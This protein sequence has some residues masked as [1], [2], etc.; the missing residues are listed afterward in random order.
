MN[1]LITGGTGLLGKAIINTMRP[2]INIASTFD[3]AY[4]VDNTDIVKHLKV[5][6]LD[7]KSYIDL[8]LSF[9]PEYIIHCAS[10]G[11]PDFAELN[12]DLTWNVNVAGTSNIVDV[13]NS[14]G[15][16]L[17][18]ISSNG[19]YSGDSPPYSEDSPANPINFYGMTKLEGEKISKTA[20]NGC[21]IVRPILM[22]G[23]NNSFERK[24]IVTSSL[25]K[26]RRNEIVYA[27]NDVFVSP[28]Y[29][30]QCASAI[31]NIITN[32]IAGDFNIG[33]AERA[34][35]YDLLLKTAKIFGLNQDLVIP[36]QQGFFKELVKRPRDTS[37]STLKMEK[38]LGI[39]PLTLEQGLSLMKKNI[40][41]N[42]AEALKDSNQ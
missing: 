39:K 35:I 1:I 20:T 21:V 8:A 11:S 22:Y 41:R 36:V 23:W 26:L 30:E 9:K 10:I 15:A 37:F 31:W 29:S 38:M 7:K 4:S 25:E 40:S 3:G 32:N 17:I 33:G 16:K 18:Y 24:N 27:Y 13:C 42:D 28:L 34:S 14:V 5:N 6:I 12:K 19:L 2:G